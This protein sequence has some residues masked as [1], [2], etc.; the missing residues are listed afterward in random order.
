MSGKC[1][2][3]IYENPPVFTVIF[4]NIRGFGTG[5]VPQ[6]SDG[7]GRARCLLSAQAGLPVTIFFRI[8]D[9]AM[10]IHASVTSRLDYCKTFSRELPLKSIQKLQLV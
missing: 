10:V 4:R 2:F 9:L 1:I 8:K 7:G 5:T 6:Y 3:F